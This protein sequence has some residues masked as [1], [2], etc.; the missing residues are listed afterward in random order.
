MSDEVEV[1]HS[2]REAVQRSLAS[3]IIHGTGRKQ[4]QIESNEDLLLFEVNGNSAAQRV[5]DTFYVVHRDDLPDVTVNKHG[6]TVAM[7]REG[8]IELGYADGSDLATL[9][10]RVRV[11]VANLL[12]AEA[13]VEAEATEQRLREATIR[14]AGIT[15]LVPVIAAAY[16]ESDEIDVRV[17]AARLWDGGLRAPVVEEDDL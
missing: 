7:D 11:H 17:M 9:R 13:E 8:H 4:G 3:R 5:L 1:I 15:D 2:Q 12:R 14:S 10:R 16:P 6:V